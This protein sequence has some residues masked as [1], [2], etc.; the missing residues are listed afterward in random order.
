MIFKF[1]KKRWLYGRKING[2]FAEKN[3]FTKKSRKD[4][5]ALFPAINQPRGR[6]WIPADP[7]RNPY[8]H[9]YPD[10]YKITHSIARVT[11]QFSN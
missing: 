8:E 10:P 2:L 3:V 7:P 5:P 6:P 9:L 11:R 1:A 4:T